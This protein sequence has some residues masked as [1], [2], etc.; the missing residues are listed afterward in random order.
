M[1]MTANDFAA[2]QVSV[3]PISRQV[4]ER[5]SDA[6]FSPM[7]RRWDSYWM[8]TTQTQREGLSK[9]LNDDHIDTALKRIQTQSRDTR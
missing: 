5:F 6:D 9:Y 4:E 8:A 3:L 1:K 2:L 7:R